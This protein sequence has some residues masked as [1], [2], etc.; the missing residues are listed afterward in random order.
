MVVAAVAAVC[1]YVLCDGRPGSQSAG[2]TGS[3]Q[4]T[5]KLV[6]DRVTT[7]RDLNTKSVVWCM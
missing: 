6:R 3:R 7:V 5:G 2:R 4:R 1:E